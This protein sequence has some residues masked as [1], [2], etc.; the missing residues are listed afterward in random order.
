MIDKRKLKIGVIASEFLPQD[1]GMENYALNLTKYFEKFGHEVHLFC[2]EHATEM[3][4]II[5]HKILTGDLFH[6][7]PRLRKCEMDIWLAINSSYGLLALYKKNVFISVHGNDFLNPWVRFCFPWMDKKFIWRFKDRCERGVLRLFRRFALKRVQGILA[8]S[9]FTKERFL[10]IY[11]H[12]K[13]KVKV[14]TPGV[15]PYFLANQKI[16][17]QNRPVNLL[18]VT[19][20]LYPPH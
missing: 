5:S 13:R 20:K 15:D 12:L 8:N 18:T 16:S 9:Q 1:G 4:N 10:Q 19:R 7:L 17:R 11:P 3:P 2:K 6:D 14:I